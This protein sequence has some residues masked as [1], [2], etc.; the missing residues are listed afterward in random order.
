LV[1][2]HTFEYNPLT[3]YIMKGIII[4]SNADLKR[5]PEA[6][7]ILIPFCEYIEQEGENSLFHSKEGTL[8]TMICVLLD[9]EIKYTLGFKKAETSSNGKQSVKIASKRT[10][11]IAQN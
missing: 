2:F 6:E 4:L 1:L 5:C 7:D 3:V 11:K 8:M 10:N 9:K